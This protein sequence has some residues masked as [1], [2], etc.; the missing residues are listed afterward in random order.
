[1]VLVWGCIMSSCCFTCFWCDAPEGL[2]LEC[3]KGGEGNEKPV[4][5]N[6]LCGDYEK[7]AISEF[8]H[9]DANGIT[10]VL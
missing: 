1:L 10:V 4:S 3:V 8:F 5:H 9:V 2:R 6:D 7:S